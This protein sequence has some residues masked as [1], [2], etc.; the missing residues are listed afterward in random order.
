MHTRRM[1]VKADKFFK[2]PK[3]VYEK[4][5][6]KIIMEMVWCICIASGGDATETFKV[7]LDY[8]TTN[9]ISQGDH[10]SLSYFTPLQQYTTKQSQNF[11]LLFA[12][13]LMLFISTSLCQKATLA[14]LPLSIIILVLF[15][16]YM[17]PPFNSPRRHLI[18]GKIL[19][20]KDLISD[21]THTPLQPVH[22]ILHNNITNFKKFI[23]STNQL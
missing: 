19:N 7:K 1:Q 14:K 3:K 20:S 15:L 9:K 10:L 12:F 6:G 8:R 16:S 21:N 13:S 4:K 18:I 22:L 17:A 5:K 23:L 2:V 11:S